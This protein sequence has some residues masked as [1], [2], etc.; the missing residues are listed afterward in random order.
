MYMYSKGFYISLYFIDCN[1]SF[2]VTRYTA[3][4][5]ISVFCSNDSSVALFKFC[6]L[7]AFFKFL[8]EAASRDKSRVWRE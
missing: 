6:L 3:P 5:L 8:F 7:N 1:S 4:T 2:V